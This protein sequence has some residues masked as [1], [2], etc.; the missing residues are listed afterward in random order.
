ML[1]KYFLKNINYFFNLLFMLYI[2]T[3]LTSKYA[4]LPIHV[5]YTITYFKSSWFVII[6]VLTY[7]MIGYSSNML[8]HTIHLFI[9]FCHNNL[10]W[11]SDGNICFGVQT[12]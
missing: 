3:I 1:K 7:L 11:T 6:S 9:I 2:N 8:L 4:I 12:G 10:L 5:L